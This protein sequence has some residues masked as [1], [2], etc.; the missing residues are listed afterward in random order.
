MDPISNVDQVVLLLRQRLAE[1]ARG[2]SPSAG[3]PAQ[4]PV[5]PAAPDVGGL[6]ALVGVEGV[7]DRQLKRA[8]VQNLLAEQFGPDL[9]NDARFQQVVDR[10]TETI[11]DEGDSASLLAR[12]VR[13]LRDVAR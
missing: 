4:R 1:R 3:A 11:E 5:Q 9:I 2:A 10:V 8:L 13:D 6:R 12:V 7:G